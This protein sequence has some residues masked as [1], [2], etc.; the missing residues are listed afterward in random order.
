[1]HNKPNIYY[2]IKSFNSDEIK[3]LSRNISIIYRNYED[4]LDLT[5]IKKIRDMCAQQKR[6]FYISNN[7]KVAQNLKL[8]GVYIPSFNT[9]TNLKNLSV[10]KKFKIIGSAHS[11]IELINKERQGCSEVFIAPVFKTVKSKFFLDIL[12]FNLISISS[13]V[14]IIALGGINS[15]NYSKLK[16]ASCF[17][18]AAIAWIKKTGLKK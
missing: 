10:L 4:K 12:K 5:I 16:S 13:T 6:S 14:K 7:L 9:L 11:K 15:S 3:N 1:M 18:F 8:D 17:G 2:F